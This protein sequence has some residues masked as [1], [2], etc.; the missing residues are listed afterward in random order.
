MKA[1]TKDEAEKL[2]CPYKLT[3]G[4]GGRGCIADSCMS[5]SWRV[6][7]TKT[8]GESLNSGLGRENHHP[9]AGICELISKG[10]K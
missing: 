8:G 9:K 1:L 10:G 7:T 6:W 5:W 4:E 3:R 2:L